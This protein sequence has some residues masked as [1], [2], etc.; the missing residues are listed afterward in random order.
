MGW[1]FYEADEMGITRKRSVV[2]AG[3]LEK[4]P[5]EAHAWQGSKESR[6]QRVQQSASQSF[7]TLIKRYLQEAL[8]ERYSTRKSY[9]SI[10]KRHVS[11]R[12]EQAPIAEVKKPFKVEQWLKELK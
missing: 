5:T 2:L 10:L 3:N 4:W 1:R 8:P 11:P 12:W 9:L 7:G 6:H